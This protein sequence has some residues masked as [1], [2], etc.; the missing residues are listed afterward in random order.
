MSLWSA[1]GL[2]DRKTVDNLLIELQNLR[3]ETNLLMLENQ[4]LIAEKI[5]KECG[6]ILQANAANTDAVK[7]L[8]SE[9]CHNLSEQSERISERNGHQL[10]AE[11]ASIRK[12]VTSAKE[13]M[14]SQFLEMKK[15]MGTAL[16]NQK[17]I[18]K[19]I[20]REAELRKTEI[21]SEIRQARNHLGDALQDMKGEFSDTQKAS[22]AYMENLI[23]KLNE[24]VTSQNDRLQKQ[25]ADML[26]RISG[27]QETEIAGIDAIG[28][29]QREW[30]VEIEKICLSA[31]E[32]MKQ[33]SGK[34]QNMQADEEENLNRIK[35]LSSQMQELGSRQKAVMERLSQLCQD[36]SQ[37]ME[38]Q[39]SIN[40]IWEIMK[41]V[42]VDSLLN[43]YRR[44][45]E[46]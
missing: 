46:E 26:N 14:D 1:I 22:S 4:K 3:K 12:I 18:R 34:Y 20:G 8:V 45:M 40:D 35:E 6:D 28:R 43:E 30:M 44:G 36:S 13:Q 29:S 38:I 5:D 41:A 23:G 15:D 19:D 39:K 24:T 25:S 27:Q 17:E 7:T 21:R 11:G 33:T 9:V 32:E 31:L 42:W 37:F 2:A 10:N 16:E